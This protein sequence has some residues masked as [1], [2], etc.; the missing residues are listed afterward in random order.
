M[1]Q[2]ESVEQYLSEQYPEKYYSTAPDDKA[3]ISRLRKRINE[4]IG[5]FESKGI[6]SPHEGNY[7]ELNAWGIIKER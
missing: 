2:N 4:S 3:Y 6:T 5:Y 7:L 1:A